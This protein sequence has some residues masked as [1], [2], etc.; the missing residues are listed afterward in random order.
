MSSRTSILSI[1][2]EPR[3]C[4]M[5]H[6]VYNELGECDEPRLNKGNGDSLCHKWSNKDLLAMLS[7]DTEAPQDKKEGR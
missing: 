1:P 2:M 4:P 3:Q 6:C 5:R 7:D